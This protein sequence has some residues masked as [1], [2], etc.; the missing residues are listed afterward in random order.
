MVDTQVPR[1]RRDRTR[2]PAA[3]PVRVADTVD[4]PELPPQ[5]RRKPRIVE[6]AVE[7]ADRA[8]LARW[9][10]VG[11]PLAHRMLRGRRQVLIAL[12]SGAAA[13]A[14]L[15]TT[16]ATAFGSPART[17]ARG[18][19]SPRDAGA[20][21]DRDASYVSGVGDIN[22]LGAAGLADTPSAAA[23]AALKA[24]PTYSTPLSRDPVLHLLRRATFGPTPADVTAVRQM[25]LDAW[26]EQQL[27]PE[28]VADPGGDAVMALY[29]SLAQTTA[30]LRTSTKDTGAPM[31]EL[32]RA[33]L[34]RQIWS[35]RQLYE[36][37]V[38]FWANHLNVRNPLDG[39]D[40]T[41]TTYDRDVIRKF[42]LGRFA[43]MLHASARHPAMLHYLNNDESDRRSVNE[44]Y[45]RELLELH[46][47]GISG[48][49]TEVDVR[50]SA[51]IM[52][53]RTVDRDDMFT[54]EA[55]RHYVGKVK[56][57]D[58]AHPNNSAAGGLALGDAYVAYLAT[59]PATARNIAR[60]LAVRF[61]CDSP[62]P[63]LVDRLADAY[64]KNGTAIVPVLR[65][66]FRS[67]EFWIATGL[68]TRRPLEHVV[69]TA[70]TLGVT[71][72]ANP[73]SA[74][75]ELFGMT[76]DLG[77]APLAWIPPNGYPDVAAA[78]NSAHAMLGAW[79]A[80]RAL[81]QGMVRGLGYP[82]PEALVA[83]RP[84]TTGG[85]VDALA[86]RL[87]FQPMS[88]RERQAVLGFLGAGDGSRPAD[89][90]LGGK[91]QHVAPLFL[92]SV[93]HSLR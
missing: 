49:Y 45:G 74:L 21:A 63:P 90:T 70:R 59:H 77:Q 30:Q 89:A 27:N 51:Y 69:A 11:R 48:G 87:V 76:E 28:P 9:L 31:R 12:G 44:N 42:A 26:I 73:K 43:E 81:V 53:G 39:G 61:V 13:M 64:L 54:Y 57:L 91:V 38:D 15:G 41:R 79:N 75:D 23:A 72:G 6:R 5:P 52:T 93:Y 47:V 65:V 83:N 36:V 20:F 40:A 67:L 4:E 32:G 56:V 3:E 71:P 60:K 24:T 34:G 84:A 1:T 50:Q 19:R 85:Y 33:T 10:G 17:A 62:P 86:A 92:D 2:T 55:R 8:A 14:A 46:T 7:R 78:W 66:L 82:R 37:M 35:S 25:G 29:P 80:H 88:A 18:G 68:K 58:F 22:N 16:V